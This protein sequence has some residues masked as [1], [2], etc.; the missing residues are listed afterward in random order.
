MKHL[1]TLIALVVAVTAG[2]QG[3]TIHEYPW[4]PDSNNDNLIGVDDLLDFLPVFGDEFG[5]PP[6]PCDYDGTPL[7]ELAIGIAQGAIVLDS[8]Y[9]EYELEDI[10]TYYVLG[11]PDPITDTLIFA[12]SAM[13]YNLSY[14][15][16]EW[17]IWGW[18]DYG[19]TLEF[20]FEW[21]TSNGLYEWICRSGSIQA[22]GFAEDNFFSGLYITSTPSSPL[23]FPE[24]W[25]LNEEGIHLELDRWATYAN[26]LHILPYW[27]YAE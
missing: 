19:N 26:Y 16:T 27:H 6:E 18:D 24:E 11:C 14:Y 17:I 4:N 13:L 15:D 12:N 9:I 5:N 1:M 8:I 23:P 20:E 2:A 3:T 7:E 10:A 22:L 21:D 25:F